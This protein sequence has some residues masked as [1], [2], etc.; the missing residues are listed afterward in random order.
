VEVQQ[1]QRDLLAS[2]QQQLEAHKRVQ[3]LQQQLDEAAEQL[4]A[5]KH[6]LSMSKVDG[7][8]LQTEVGA[9][10]SACMAMLT[11]CLPQVLRAT[12]RQ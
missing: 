3:A 4:A 1:L 6:D 7:K 5:A 10:G 12:S 8:Q 2:K 9:V 11:Y